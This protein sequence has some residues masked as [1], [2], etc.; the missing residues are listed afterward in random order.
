MIII[1]TIIFWLSVL[2]DVINRVFH[3]CFSACPV[4]GRHHN[5]HWCVQHVRAAVILS[6]IVVVIFLTSFVVSSP[7]LKAAG[8]IICTVTGQTCQLWSIST[9]NASSNISVS[10]ISFP[11]VLDEDWLV[12]GCA[13]EQAL[14]V[15][16]K[17]NLWFY[18]RHTQCSYAAA[19]A[20]RPMMSFLLKP[21]TPPPIRRR[22]RAWGRSCRCCDNSCGDDNRPDADIQASSLAPRVLLFACA[23]ETSWCTGLINNLSSRTVWG[24]LLEES[25]YL[26]TTLQ[27][28]SCLQ[29]LLARTQTCEG[30]LP[31]VAAV[32]RKAQVN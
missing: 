6:T 13:V 3:S 30:F 17:H 21:R 25:I 9:E 26:A 1:A 22:Y 11:W 28:S 23:L 7:L 32:A 27:H 2:A 24:R 31:A 18:T 19:A 15:S 4:H 20:S 12:Y 16:I 10:P 5:T 8:E 29:Q 14:L